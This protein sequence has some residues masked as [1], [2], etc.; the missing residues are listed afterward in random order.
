MGK[1]TL[2]PTPTRRGEVSGSRPRIRV[3]HQGKLLEL[4]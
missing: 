4:C 3:L 1:D 2:N